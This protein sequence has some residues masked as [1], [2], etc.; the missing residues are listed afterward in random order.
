[1]TSSS[2]PAPVDPSRTALLVMDYQP[3]ILGNYPNAAELIERTADALAQARA[4]GLKIVYVRVA[5]TPQ[6]YAA[7]PSRNKG[8][9]AIAKAGVLDDGTPE[10]AIHPDVAPEGGDI[11]VTKTRR[12]AFR[13]PISPTTCAPMAST[14]SSSPASPPAGLCYRPSVTPPTTTTGSS[15]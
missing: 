11:V 12:G 3:F 10:A 7:I 5:F 13:R 1:M 2:T 8:F 6:D 14:A 4:A 15:S 9:A